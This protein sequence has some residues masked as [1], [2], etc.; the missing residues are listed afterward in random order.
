VVVSTAAWEA[1]IY[2]VTAVLLG[3]VG[4]LA[5]ALV[6]AWAVASDAPGTFPAWASEPRA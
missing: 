6:G 2:V 1:V 3:A 4:V 5:T